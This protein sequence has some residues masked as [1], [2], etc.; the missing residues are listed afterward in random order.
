LLQK[1]FEVEMEQIGVDL[2]VALAIHAGDALEPAFLHGA[3][4]VGTYAGLLGDISDLEADGQP[5]FPQ[6]PA[7][8]IHLCPP[9]TFLGN[10]WQCMDRGVLFADVAIHYHEAEKKST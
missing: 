7:D 5:L 8:V 1:G 10:A 6:N 9:F 2:Q 3:E 4:V